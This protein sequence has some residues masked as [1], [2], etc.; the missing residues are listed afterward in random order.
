MV[1]R[2][3]SKRR[4]EANLLAAKKGG[5]DKSSST[6]VEALPPPPSKRDVSAIPAKLRRIM[7][8]K[9]F[10]QKGSPLSEPGV[11]LPTGEN[12][13]TKGAK[14]KSVGSASGEPP[15]KKSAAGGAPAGDQPPGPAGVAAG[16]AK[17]AP[18]ESRF[19]PDEG[20]AASSG[21]RAA[22]ERVP[23]GKGADLYRIAAIG[24]GPGHVSKRLSD[25]KREYLEKKKL[26]KKLK[27]GAALR[28]G[29]GSGGQ[30]PSARSGAPHQGGGGAADGGDSPPPSLRS[31]NEMDVVAFGDVVMAPPK[32]SSK[33][34][35]RAQWRAKWR[36]QRKQRTISLTLEA[37]RW[38]AK[39]G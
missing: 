30:G 24:A 16:K 26:K 4:R 34:R 17:R 6:L 2:G 29:A 27:G 5:G 21:A 12:G 33:P 11:A 1:S 25:K 15:S 8:M 20:Q 13:S 18:G 19:P 37:Y 31:L 28:L 39:R 32:L 38:Q 35:E 36:G 22:K 23:G 10:S 9:K 14:R 3:K 7:E